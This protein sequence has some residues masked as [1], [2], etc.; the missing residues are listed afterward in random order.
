[1]LR[2]AFRQ[3]LTIP[4]LPSANTFANVFSTLTGF[5]YRGLSPP[6]ACVR[7]L[8][9]RQVHAHAGGRT[10]VASVD[11]RSLAAELCE[12]SSKIQSYAAKL[13]IIDLDLWKN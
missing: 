9:G 1:M 8:T 13:S 3:N 12:P 11:E 10:H 4:P 2:F 5:T 6:P 7:T